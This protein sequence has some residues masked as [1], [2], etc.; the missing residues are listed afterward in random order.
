ML[1]QEDRNARRRPV[2]DFDAHEDDPDDRPSRSI[3]GL[4]DV[5]PSAFSPSSIAP[6]SEEDPPGTSFLGLAGIRVSKASW[7]TPPARRED[8]PNRS[9]LGLEGIEPA[10]LSSVGLAQGADGEPPNESMLGLWSVLPRERLETPPAR[11]L[12][13]EPP[14]R[15]FLGV[16]GIQADLFPPPVV[17][18][19]RREASPGPIEVPEFESE[20]AHKPRG[21][22]PIERAILFSLAAHIL[23]VVLFLSAPAPRLSGSHGGLLA[24]LMPPEEKTEQKIP[25]IFREFRESPGPARQNSRQSDLSDKTRRAG[26][27]EK[28]RP[29]SQTPFI[30]QRPGMEGLEPGG[31]TK[32]QPSQPALGQ[33]GEKQ[34][35]M[36]P[37]ERAQGGPEAFQILPPGPNSARRGELSG[38][39]T[40]VEEAARAT[41]QG[42]RGAGFPNPHGGS[43]DT[44]PVSF[45]TT[46]YPWGE[47][48][49][50]MLRRLRVHHPEL[51]DPF[52][53]WVT[54]QWAIQPDGRITELQKVSSSGNPAYDFMAY[55]AITGSDP[56]APL[57]KDLLEQVGQDHREHVMVTFIYNMDRS[58]WERVRRGAN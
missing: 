34:A 42:E 15:S 49:E 1:T 46:W 38:L 10:E 45:E 3:L 2:F 17:S 58:E 54:Y 5:R 56:F 28:D 9:F 41:V 36:A 37:G 29:R 44:G 18:G 12:Q 14:G 53:G 39:D 26:G 22:F 31:K 27:G 40:A 20:V 43:V 4:E 6:R 32:S 21:A 13:K 25:V 7:T 16:E 23:L 48:M 11:E 51:R 19:V 57:P 35:A 47:Y 30:A 52:K 24:A 50:A 8:P 55:Q 33:E